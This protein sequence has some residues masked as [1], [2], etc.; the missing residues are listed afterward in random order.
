[1]GVVDEF[2][3][4][5]TPHVTGPLVMEHLVN[6][7]NERGRVVTTYSSSA[8]VKRQARRLGLDFTQV[9]MGFTRIYREFS[10][11]DVLLGLEGMGGICFPAHLPERD[12]IMAALMVVEARAKA[13]KPLSEMVA[14][15]EAEIGKMTYVV[16]DIELDASS[17]QAFRNIL[18][19][20]YLPEVCGM[21]PEY[22]GH[23]DGLVLRFSDDS[24]VQLRPSRT[25]PLVRARAES[26]NPE[27]AAALGE[28]A[29]REALKHLPAGPWKI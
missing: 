20:I 26:P 24:W 14:E 6:G 19:G 8:L 3:H 4:F 10:D 27:L 12:G 23:A 2:G 21:K 11:G 29:C 18:P 17:I 15:L 13:K 25:E 9:P 16:R 7:R 28:Q 22:V 5:L 1:M